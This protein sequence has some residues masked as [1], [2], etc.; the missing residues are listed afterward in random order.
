MRSEFFFSLFFH[1]RYE[2]NKIF[3]LLYYIYCTRR[4]LH[5]T[6]VLQYS[7]IY[8]T[9]VLVLIDWLIE[10]SDLYG[11]TYSKS[12]DQQGKVASPARGH[13]NRET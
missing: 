9:I 3:V 2:Y 11:H 12:M 1:A 8:S 10:F 6:M 4:R 5:H 7:S 13:L